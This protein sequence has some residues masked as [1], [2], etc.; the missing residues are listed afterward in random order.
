[1]SR[2]RTDAFRIAAAELQRPDGVADRRERIAQLVRQH[3]QELVLAA[4][5]FGQVRRQLAQVVLQPLALGDVLADRR[6][7][8]P[9]VRVASGS[10]STL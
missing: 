6:E 7:R 3:R 5:R 10:V 1:M 9:A 8:R 4:V 2:R